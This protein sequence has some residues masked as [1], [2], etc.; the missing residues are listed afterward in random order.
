VVAASPA[1]AE[2]STTAKM[3]HRLNVERARIGLGPLKADRALSA[4]AARQSR[5]QIRVGRF[6]HASNLDGP[7]LR[8]VAELI[9]WQP[10]WRLRTG[11][12]AHGWKNSPT[13]ASL[14]ENA[15]Y[16]LAGVGWARG[17]FGG[18]PATIWT[19]RLGER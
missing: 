5:R 15:S 10:G 1:T 19:V 17:W 8:R 13:H 18:R 6:E 12:V 4:G 3:I 14:V 9:A 2:A 7:G 11:P 16:R